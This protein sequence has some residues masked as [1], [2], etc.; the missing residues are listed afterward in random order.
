MHASLINERL[1]DQVAD[2][3]DTAE[4]SIIAQKPTINT[5]LNIFTLQKLQN[6]ILTITLSNG[7]ACLFFVCTHPEVVFR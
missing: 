3:N 5:L 2:V 7:C 6:K 1:C 4:G